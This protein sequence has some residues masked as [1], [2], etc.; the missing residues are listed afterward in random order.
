MARLVG[1]LSPAKVSALVKAGTV[2]L[3][4]DGGNLNLQVTGAGRASWLFRYSRDGR[5]REMGL[6]ATHTITLAEAR[7]A[8]RKLRQRLLEGGDPLAERRQAKAAPAGMTFD[9]VADLF[10]TAKAPGWRSAIH[11]RQWR[12]SLRDHVSPLIGTMP[13]EQIDTGAIM[14]VL[15]PIWTVKAETASRIRARM[16]SI[17]DYAIS[18]GWRGEPNPARWKGHLQNLL[19]AKAKVAPVEHHPAM[20]WKAVPAFLASLAGRQG[21]AAPALVFLILTA[22]RSAEA[23]GATWGEIDLDAAVWTVP[24]SR[25]KAAREHRVPL[26]ASALAL[27][28]TLRPEQPDLGALVFPGGKPGKPLSDVALAKLLPAGATAHGMRSAFRTWAGEKTGHAREVVEMALA[29]RLGDA[30]EQAYARGDLFQKRRLLMD[31]WAAFCAGAEPAEGDNVVP[32]RV[33]AA[34]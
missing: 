28:R 14:R 26:A 10:I 16:E 24:P 6:G 9:A 3:H 17:L 18:R 29:H 15:D 20:D 2:G 19:A 30:V 4:G 1:K 13:V 22:A 21:T 23:R 11:G 7:E 27:L 34:A 25:M 12:N 31:A 5:A 33:G 8:A 32:L